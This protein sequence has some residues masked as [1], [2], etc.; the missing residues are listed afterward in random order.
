MRTVACAGIGLLLLFL[1]EFGAASAGPDEGTQHVA[2]PAD[3]AKAR[4]RL[5]GFIFPHP[6]YV[7]RW[8]DEERGRTIPE[9]AEISGR[10][11]IRLLTDPG[12]TEVCEHFN[13]RY[14]EGLSLRYEDV[15]RPD[16][17]YVYDFVYYE[18]GPF[19]IAVRVYA[20]IPQPDDPDMI[21]ARTGYGFIHVYDRELNLVEGYLR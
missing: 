6:D 18:V 10:S 4:E 16:P 7:P 3:V 2:C 12:H 1:P 5:E 21:S 8:A 15:D 20:P 11:Q 14:A 19:Y 13:Q 9:L 17:A